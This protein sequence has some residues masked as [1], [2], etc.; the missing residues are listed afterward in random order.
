MKYRLYRFLRPIVVV[1][2]KGIYRIKVINKEY[3][4]KEEPFIFVGN[5]KHNYDAISLICGTKR[6]IHFLAKK[7]LMDKHGWL[8]GKLGIIPVDRTK[9][10][11]EAIEE[12]I[13]LLKQGEIIGIFPEGTH[14]KTE[15]VIMPF[16]YG[17]V[18][19]ASE[20]NVPIV[21]FAI[22]GNYKRFRSGLKIVFDKPFYVKDKKDL[23]KENIKLMN[24]IVN[25]LREKD[26]KAKKEFTRKKI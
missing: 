3:I 18:K 5:H 13:D 17:A 21:P 22:K 23:T 7:E 11:K 8:F 4:P 25:L 14:N 9:K 15:Y 20:A 6:I 1:L 16:K 24:K 10:N 2:L 12:A 26:E 19:I